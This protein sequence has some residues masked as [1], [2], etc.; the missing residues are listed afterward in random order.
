MLST[1]FFLQFFFYGRGASPSPHPSPGLHPQ[2]SFV[3]RTLHSGN[4]F[5]RTQRHF[6]KISQ[7]IFHRIFFFQP[8]KKKFLKSSESYPKICSSKS[9]E[10]KYFGHIF[11]FFHISNQPYLKIKN[12]E[13]VCF[14]FLI[15]LNSYMMGYIL[16]RIK[17]KQ[18]T[19]FRI[20]VFEIRSI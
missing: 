20:L 9:D 17:N 11:H 4:R 7:H 19:V 3:L 16:R 12:R 8:Q 1:F 10:K 6:N 15:L 14:W 18:K 13:I 2:S 5:A